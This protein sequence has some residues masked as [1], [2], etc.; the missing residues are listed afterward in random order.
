MN[1]REELLALADEYETGLQKC[2]ASGYE[3]YGP[4][5]QERQQMI[6]DALRYYARMHSPADSASIKE[7]LSLYFFNGEPGDRTAINEAAIALQRKSLSQVSELDDASNACLELAAKHGYATGH[8]DTVSD[9]IREFSAQIPLR[10]SEGSTIVWLRE[11][12][13]GTDSACWVVCN[14]I[15]PG[16][17]MFTPADHK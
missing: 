2:V 1:S 3:E 10:S 5:F 7:I 11:I 16:A 12:D 13:R 6:I 14:K 9:M 4:D 17:I 15:D 8:G